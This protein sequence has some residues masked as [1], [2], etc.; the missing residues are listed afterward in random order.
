MS[1]LA[2]IL[3]LAVSNQAAW[4]AMYKWVDEKGVTQ[5]GDTLPPQY[6]NQG[7]AEL[8]K[9]GQVIKKTGRAVTAEE[10]KALEEEAAKRKEAEQKEIDQKRHDKALLDTYTNVNEIDLSRDRNLQATQAQIESTQVRIKSVQGRLDA[11]H[12]QASIVI[13]NKNPVPADLAAEIKEAENEIKHMQESIGKR[14][15]EIE[16]IKVRFED[17]KK[18]FRELK[19]Y[20][21]AA[22]A[23]AQDKPAK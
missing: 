20:P 6:V 11:L 14:K 5:Y 19:G 13:R 15:Q 23:A 8:N 18:R 7:N 1:R 3:V 10:R 2:L 17:D 16:A 21:P 12:K 9:K 4:A 22:P